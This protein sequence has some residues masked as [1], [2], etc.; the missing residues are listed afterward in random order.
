ME[1][2]VVSCMNMTDYYY[3]LFFAISASVNWIIM[4]VC[5]DDINFYGD[6]LSNMV[7]R[8]KFGFNEIVLVVLTTCNRVYC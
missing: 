2:K 8:T 6:P 4:R 5:I 7:K 1:N 3:Y